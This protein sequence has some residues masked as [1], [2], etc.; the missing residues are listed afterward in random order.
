MLYVLQH[1][2]HAKFL[3]GD[4]E[5]VRR[6]QAVSA[7]RSG[8][9]QRTADER[10]RELTNLT[11]AGHGLNEADHMTVVGRWRHFRSRAAFTISVCMCSRATEWQEQVMGYFS[12]YPPP[13][14]SP[15]P[16]D[17]A[18]ACEAMCLAIGKVYEESATFPGKD[19]VME[20]VFRTLVSRYQ[21]GTRTHRRSPLLLD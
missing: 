1:Q 17:S 15:V 13:Q 6:K 20:E 19:P 16:F 18:L 14:Y 7:A 11:V 12:E 4:S 21:S 10:Y 3:S 9:K 2:V 8:H 5:E